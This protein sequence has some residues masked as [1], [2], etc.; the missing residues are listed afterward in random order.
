[1]TAEKNLSASIQSYNAALEKKKKMDLERNDK[2]TI[3]KESKTQL[4]TAKN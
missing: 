4:S 1:M 3:L 2:I